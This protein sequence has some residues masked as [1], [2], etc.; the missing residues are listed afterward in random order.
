MQILWTDKLQDRFHGL[1][2][3]VICPSFLTLYELKCV[4]THMLYTSELNWE[5]KNGEKPTVSMTGYSQVSNFA[6]AHK[7]LDT[8]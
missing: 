6:C 8:I 2:Q 3:T 4:H 1:P 7:Y 5:K